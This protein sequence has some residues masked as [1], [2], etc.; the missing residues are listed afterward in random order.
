LNIH[1]REGIRVVT[2]AFEAVAL[3]RRDASGQIATQVRRAISEGVWVPGER[4]P[5]EQELA[6]SFDVSRAT[7]REA[8]K[9][10]AAT[11]L[12]SSSRGSNGGTFVTLPDADQVAAQLS[13]AIQMWYRS[14]NV[15]LRDVDEARW[16]LEMHCVDLAA[17]RRT[18]EDLAKMLEAIERSRDPELDMADWL[19]LDLVFH[20]AV[21]GAAKNQ[22]LELAMR[23]VHL[24][25]PATNTVFVGLLD[26]DTVN[27]QH[28]AIYLAIKTEDPTGAQEAF[29]A[30][31]TYLD[32]TRREALADRDAADVLV[33][34]LPKVEHSAAERPT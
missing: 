20:S 32:R 33:A 17:R 6:D 18:D 4:L 14:G 2:K 5:T 10:L 19:D 31:V 23:A 12:V 25:R 21:T 22:I 3:G 30:H 15:T 27:D 28:H 8:I 13:D 7:A 16:V 26:R 1:A 34:S 24:A 29:R 9:L 11:G